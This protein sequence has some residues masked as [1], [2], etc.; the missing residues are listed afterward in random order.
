MHVS[1]LEEL[2][3]IAALRLQSLRSFVRA[4]QL[5]LVPWRLAL[6]LRMRLVTAAAP[7]ATDIVTAAV[8]AAAVH[9]TRPMRK[10]AF[11]KVLP[12]FL[13]ADG[14]GNKADGSSDAQSQA[15]YMQR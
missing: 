4:L 14:P 12:A 2:S 9:W 13:H 5:C 1:D 3:I 10:T 15:Y 7:V 8:A 11:L 6:K